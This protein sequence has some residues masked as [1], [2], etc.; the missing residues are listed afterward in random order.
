MSATLTAPPAMHNAGILGPG[1]Q[2]AF[3]LNITRGGIQEKHRARLYGHIGDLI[4]WL[5]I[6][7]VIIGA[8]L[9]IR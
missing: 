2:F 6:G 8:V 1:L 4:V 3:P 9:T 5:V 7:S